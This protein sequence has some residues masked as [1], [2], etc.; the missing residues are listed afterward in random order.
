MGKG[1]SAERE[2]SSKLS[3]WWSH[4][5]N[6]DIFYRTNA[7]GARFTQ[8]RKSGKNINQ[9]AG[10][11]CAQDE[12]GKALMCEWLIEC[13]SGYG[14]KTKVKDQAGAVVKS[15]QMRWDTLDIVDSAQKTPKLIEF[16]EQ[17]KRDACLTNRKP[18]LIFRRNQRELCIAIS[19]SYFLN[20]QGFF[21]K[22]SCNTISIKSPSFDLELEIMTLKHF[23]EWIPDIRPSLQGRVRKLNKRK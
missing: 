3:L 13:K 7:S 11:I 21:G 9:Q 8:N 6:K 1:G 18:I 12:V 17:C 16:W 2:I 20:L 22:P 5:E 10:D 23:F 19:H 15:I 14:G 4:G